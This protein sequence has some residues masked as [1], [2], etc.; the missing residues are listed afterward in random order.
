MVP[1]TWNT[2][3]PESGHFSASGIAFLL[4]KVLD[5]IILFCRKKVSKCPVP[6]CAVWKDLTPGAT[7]WYFMTTWEANNPDTT[8]IKVSFLS[9]KRECTWKKFCCLVGVIAIVLSSTSYFT[10]PDHQIGKI[11]IGT[12]WI[13]VRNSQKMSQLSNRRGVVVHHDNVRHTHIWFW[14]YFL[15]S[16]EMFCPTSHTLRTLIRPTTICFFL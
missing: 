4:N 13:E 6:K 16:I 8:A 15:H 3:A 2:Y 9:L 5:I 12:W 7:V 10:K 14:E 11:L 1:V